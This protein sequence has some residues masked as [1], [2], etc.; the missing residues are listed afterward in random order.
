M[1]ETVTLRCQL[2]IS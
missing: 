1:G 2:V